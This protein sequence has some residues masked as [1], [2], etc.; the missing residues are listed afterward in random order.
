[1]AEGINLGKAYVQIMPSAE[2]IQ[3]SISGLLAG[4]AESAGKSSGGKFSAAMGGVLKT[5]L[6]LAATGAAAVTSFAKSIVDGAKNTAS[7]GDNIDKLSQKIGLSKT[8]FQEW[9]YVFSQ[10]GTDIGILQTG[11]KTLSSALADAENGSKSA[12]AKFDALGISVKDLS[13]LS[14]EDLFSAVVNQLQGMESGAERTSIAADL[15]GKSA[16]EL[17]PLL[18]QTA[19]DTQALKDQ[20]HDLGMIMSDEAVASSAAFTDAMDN[21]SRAAAGAKNQLSANFLPGLTEVT[22]GLAGLIAGTDGA[23]DQITKGFEQIVGGIEKA[24]PGIVDTISGL[25]KSI[26]EVAPTLIQTLATALIASIPELLPAA[27]DLILQLAEMLIS[28]APQ[29]IEVGLQVI[30]QLVLGI[31]DALPNL[32]PAA[33]DAILAIVDALIDNIDLLVDAS[34]AITIALAEGLINALPKLIEKAPEIVTKLVEALIRNAPKLLEAA[35]ELVVKL[36]E[37]IVNNLPQIAHAAGEIIATLLAGIGNLFVSIYNT[38]KEIG[39]NIKNG[40]SEFISNAGTWGRDLINNFVDGI[41]SKIGDVIDAAMS[42]ANTVRDY[43]G[44]SEPDKGPLANFHTFAPDM[45]HLFAA[46]IDQNVGIVMNSVDKLGNSLTDAFDSSFN[47]A[48]FDVS[49]NM[50]SGGQSV[51]S[52]VNMGGVT[53]QVYGAPGMDE[54]Y[55]AQQVSNILNRQYVNARAVFA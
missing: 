7:M 5:G 37:G 9:D 17:G 48:V 39:E 11:M 38:G 29:L 13:G 2:G 43:L 35:F 4:E 45:M 41:W 31:A 27:T 54:T 50:S 8:A 42:V 15:L 53:I 14:Q 1:M 12:I 21:L 51:G 20:A 44:F 22:N 34:I 23:A 24:L 33:V 32:I 10:N 18:N 52:S 49:A 25:A 47:D 16:T 26:A 19:E 6:G 46:G 36:V 40:F 55:L 30:L 3:G 28:M